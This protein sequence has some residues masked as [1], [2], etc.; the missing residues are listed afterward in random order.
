MNTDRQDEIEVTAIFDWIKRGFQAVMLAILGFI[1]FIL[2]NAIIIL[3]LI[4]IGA[5]IGWFIDANKPKAF[6]ANLIVHINQDAT[7]YVYDWVESFN[8]KINDSLYRNEVAFAKNEIVGLEIEPIVNYKD[9]QTEFNNQNTDILKLLIE[10]NEDKDI[11]IS[12]S[13]RNNYSYH[14]I[15]LN[16]EENGNQ[17]TITKIIDLLNSNSYFISL[18]TIEKEFSKRK[19]DQMESSLKQVDSSITIYNKGLASGN[20]SNSVS[21]NSESSTLEGLFRIKQSLLKEINKETENLI[22]SNRPIILVNDALIIQTKSFITKSKFLIPLILVL[23]FFITAGL[24]NMYL[25]M[26]RLSYQKKN[27]RI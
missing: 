11:L 3:I 2:K 6:Q 7:E 25:Y 23:G 27:E 12:E 18:N 15:K 9:L 13:L 14:I 21:I 1:N 20:L 17:K 16:L 4:V 5:I 19:I 10:S 24:F 22:S 26:K 8:T